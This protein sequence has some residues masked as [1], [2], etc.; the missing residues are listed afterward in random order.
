MCYYKNYWFKK[1]KSMLHIKNILIKVDKA[2]VVNNFSLDMVPGSLHLLIGPNG[3]GKSSIVQMLLGNP[4]YTVAEGAV[5]FQGQDLL[6]LAPFE[7]AR[8][9][10]FIVQQEQVPIAG[11][12]VGIYLKAMYDALTKNTDDVSSFL[13]KA[14]TVFAMVGLDDSFIDRCVHD[15]FSGGQ[16]KRFE[17]AQ[18]VLCKPQCVIFDEIDAGL[19]EEGKQ[20]LI[21][22]IQQMRYENPLFTALFISHNQKLYQVFDHMHKHHINKMYYE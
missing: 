9:G 2:V 16:K 7:R 6:T 15:G 11:L 21:T 20:L 17:L 22:I 12:S 13:G 1:Y 4:V 19:D 14:K 18:V 8:K 5:Q 10:L 3:S